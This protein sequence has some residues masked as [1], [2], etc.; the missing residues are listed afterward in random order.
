[1]TEFY[2]IIKNEPIPPI[3]NNLDPIDWEI[4]EEGDCV[5]V[6]DEKRASNLRSR[7]DHYKKMNPHNLKLA[8]L[9]IIWRKAKSGDTTR[10]VFFVSRY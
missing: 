3:G 8:G 1:M 10:K 2:K 4:I 7:F 5:L 9:K 6:E